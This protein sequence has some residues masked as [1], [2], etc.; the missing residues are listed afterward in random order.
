MFF[1]KNF[2]LLVL[3]I[4]LLAVSSPAYFK[5]NDTGEEAF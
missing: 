2:P 3:P 1:L 5:K 4:L